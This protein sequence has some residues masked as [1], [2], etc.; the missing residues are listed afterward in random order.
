MRE[1]LQVDSND[2]KLKK[3]NLFQALQLLLKKD[4][5][6]RDSTQDTINY[7]RMYSNGI[8]EVTDNKYSKMVRFSDISYQLSQ[9][10]IKQTIFAHYSTLLNSF[11][12]SVKIQLNFINYRMM[13][14]RDYDEI[15]TTIQENT[16]IS[17]EQYELLRKEYLA[18]LQ[19]QQEKGSNGIIRDKYLVFSVY[20]KSYESANRRLNSIESTIKTNFQV[21]GVHCDEVTGVERLSIINYLLNEGTKNY[22]DVSEIETKDF[23]K[24]PTKDFIAPRFLN[25]QPEYFRIN[26]KVGTTMN[27]SVEASELSD[28]VLSDFL[29]LELE[30]IVSMHLYSIEQ[31]KAIKMVRGKKS[32]LDKI[33]I[34]EQKK[35]NEAGYDMDILP[36]DLNLNVKE[37]DKILRELQRENEKFFFLTFTITVLEST[38]K[39]LDNAIYTLQNIASRQNCSLKIMKNQ[40]EKAFISALPLG[41]DLNEEEH[42][43]GL[44]TSSTAI[45][46][47]FTTQELYQEEDEPVYY[48]LNALSNNLIQVSRKSLRN[49]N[50]LMLGTPG[51][52]KSFSAKREMIDVYLRSSDDIL[53]CDPEGEYYPFIKR[54]GGDEIRIAIDSTDFINPLDI[55]LDYGEGENPIAFKSDF[56]LTMMEV[57]AGGKTGLTPK[58]KSIVDRCVQVIYK[59]FLNNPIE[60]N[61]P[62]LEDLYN[63][64]LNTKTVEGNDLA[65]SLELYVHGSLNVFNH[66][67]TI[68]PDNRLLCFNI[69]ELGSNLRQL[70]MLVLQDHV[71]NK[72]TTNRNIRNTWYYMDEFH[73]LLEDEQTSEYSVEFWKRFRKWGGIPTGITQNVKD[74]L[75]SPKIETIIENSDFIYLLNQAS[76]DRNILQNKLEISDYQSTYITN[77]SEGEGLI[78]YDGDI[79][80]F[81]DKFPKNNSLYPVMT[82]KPEEI[83]GYEEQNLR[84]DNS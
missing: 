69:K 6:T 45:F 62:L 49:P 75:T 72:V 19:E 33:K 58:E 60:S 77:S 52:G 59:D 39:K 64:F 37:T 65:S 57:I 27:Y 30:L 55:S 5:K 54:L 81:K 29:D 48:G 9:D 66:R 83:A 41:N 3:L 15:V 80:P 11:D 50:G 1:R 82:T 76:G 51:S 35:A 70:G 68:Q 17:L 74:L 40:Q 12:N 28:R 21:M 38:K 47:P 10:E 32:D 79:L 4:R 46:V 2:N 13:T 8:C 56:I 16:D 44:T 61:V 73:V 20:D 24:L 42:E 36:T 53:I 31:Q 14:E 71:W 25:F 7:K 34:E 23:N 43:R 18:F 84:V 22:I 63:A 26:N 67:T 78:I